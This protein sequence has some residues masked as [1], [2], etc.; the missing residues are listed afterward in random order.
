MHG[1]DTSGFGGGVLAR[2]LL[3]GAGLLEGSAWLMSSV[4]ALRRDVRSQVWLLTRYARATAGA[5]GILRAGESV[6]VQELG[7]GWGRVQFMMNLP[8]RPAS[9]AVLGR[10][11]AGLVISIQLLDLHKPRSTQQSVLLATSSPHYSRT[12][13]VCARH[14][15]QASR[16]FV[17]LQLVA[18]ARKVVIAI[19]QHSL[20]H[21]L[22]A[23]ALAALVL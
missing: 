16:A 17:E 22:Q 7:A 4:R 2:I 19:V 18:A 12:A 5:E 13:G 6:H 23:A 11:C 21:V 8:D 10:C 14:T 1:H 3:C 9:T 20:V 15:S